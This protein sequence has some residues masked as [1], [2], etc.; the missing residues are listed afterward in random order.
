MALTLRELAQRKANR[1]GISVCLCVHNKGHRVPK[2]ILYGRGIPLDY[3][4]V[5]WFKPAPEFD[6]GADERITDELM[7]AIE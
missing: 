7:R 1:K 6:K 3:H 2:L 4:G 5:E